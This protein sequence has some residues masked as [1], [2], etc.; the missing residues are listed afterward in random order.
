MNVMR[1]SRGRI[2]SLAKRGE[3][4]ELKLDLVISL[5]DFFCIRKILLLFFWEVQLYLYRE[6]IKKVGMNEGKVECF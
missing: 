5:M 2:F 1:C 4:G 3:D 6:A